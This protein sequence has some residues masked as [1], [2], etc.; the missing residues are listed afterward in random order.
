MNT[1]TIFMCVVALLIGMLV[2]NMLQNVCGCKKVE[3]FV[4]VDSENNINTGA[5]PNTDSRMS[6]IDQFIVNNQM[7][8]RRANRA[9]CGGRHTN[10]Q[11]MKISEA[12][13]ILK[14][15]CSGD[16][17][18]GAGDFNTALSDMIALGTCDAAVDEQGFVDACVASGF[19]NGQGG[20][21]AKG[22]V[23][24]CAD[25]QC[26]AASDDCHIMGLCDPTTGQCSETTAANGIPCNDDNPL[27]TGTE[28]SNGTCVS[29]GEGT[30]YIGCSNFDQFAAKMVPINNN[31]IISTNELDGDLSSTGITPVGCSQGCATAV[32]NIQADLQ[33]DCRE[34]GAGGRESWVVDF[35]DAQNEVC[36]NLVASVLPTDCTTVADGTLCDDG[37]PLTTGEECH[38][39]VC[40]KNA[41][42]CADIT[43]DALITALS[44]GGAINNVT[45]CEQIGISQKTIGDTAVPYC[46]LSVRTGFQAEEGDLDRVSNFCPETCGLCDGNGGFTADTVGGCSSERQ[47]IAKTQDIQD[48]CSGHATK[49]PTRCSPSCAVAVSSIQADL[50]DDCR[51]YA[52]YDR[53]SV[54]AGFV[55]YYISQNHSCLYGTH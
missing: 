10:S 32:S 4:V 33:G 48:E 19:S 54:G 20:G 11:S 25:V 51:N 49:D 7:N 40:V 44:A 12:E 43:D 29:A 53:D 6:A 8:G 27:T 31:C 38:L 23:S 15:L 35:V 41:A 36:Q 24:L 2:A 13:D 17:L 3:G 39:G 5:N 37:N 26:G 45:R 52:P 16:T 21:S 46:D 50:E 9:A 34:Y 18:N 47:Y 14:T 28:C 22:P 30:D 42:A 55:N 1:Q